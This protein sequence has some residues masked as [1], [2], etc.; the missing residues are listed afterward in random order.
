M[1]GCVPA[2]LSTC[3]D[4]FVLG[5]VAPSLCRPSFTYFP[6]FHQIC[7]APEI[8]TDQLIRLC[9]C[10][11]SALCSA[12]LPSAARLLDAAPVAALHASHQIPRKSTICLHVAELTVAQ[13]CSSHLRRP[14][15]PLTA[16]TFESGLLP[17][18]RHRGG[19]KQTH[20]CRANG[21]AGRAKPGRPSWPKLRHPVC[22]GRA[23]GWQ[24]A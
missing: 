1:V 21:V 9:R 3:F 12:C 17:D 10:D 5:S 18:R 23:E 19:G 6:P 7:W 22:D 13:A 16:R 2:C 11:H 8:P 14:T 24:T 15:V 20:A 4:T